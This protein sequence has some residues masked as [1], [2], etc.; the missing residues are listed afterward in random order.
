MQ[1]AEKV[2]H[3]RF[4]FRNEVSGPDAENGRSDMSDRI[5]ISNLKFEISDASDSFPVAM[6]QLEKVPWVLL[7]R[8]VKLIA[9]KEPFEEDERQSWQQ[10]VKMLL[11]F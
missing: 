6:Q 7:L 11:S 9:T 3:L 10:H 1:N 4:G 8:I 2:R 5:R